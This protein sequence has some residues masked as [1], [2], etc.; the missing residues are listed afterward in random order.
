MNNLSTAQPELNSPFPAERSQIPLDSIM[1]I[2]GFLLLFVIELLAILV[3]NDGK[4]IYTMDDTYIHLAVAEEIA[5]GHYGVNNPE[6]SAPCSSALWP[7]LIAPLARTPI[8]EYVP[9]V[10]NAL[11]GI[12]TCWFLLKEVRRVMP[13]EVGMS[14]NFARAA[15][16]GVVLL[17]CNVMGLVFSGMEH[18]LQLLLAL[19][20]A[21]GIVRVAKTG[22]CDKWLIIAAV[23]GPLIRYENLALTAVA[24]IVLLVKKRSAQAVLIGAMTGVGLGLFSWFLVANG[25]SPMPSS[26]IAKSH[27]AGDAGRIA[28]TWFALQN[29]FIDSRGLIILLLVA[30]LCG[31]ALRK[32]AGPS[33]LAALALAG[34][35]FLHAC[36]GAYGWYHRY[37]CYMFGALIFGLISLA[38]DPTNGVVKQWSR[39]STALV[40]FF[41]LVISFPYLIGLCTVPFASNNIYEQQFQMHRFVTEW[42]KKP[43]AVNDLGWVSY[44]NDRYVLDLWGLGSNKALKARRENKDFSWMPKMAEEHNVELAMVYSQWVPGKSVGWIKVG[45][46]HLSRKRITP[47]ASSVVFFATDAKYISEI[48]EKLKDFSESVPPGVAVIT[49]SDINKGGENQLPR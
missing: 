7:F 14:S 4:F 3:L 21:A 10:L 38:A 25:Q 9:L 33:K 28:S 23:C 30:A 37:E 31:L 16:T 45:E 2:G 18:N 35:G 47:A 36:F 22:E 29:S 5:R 46:I 12:M 11:L 27:L 26:I 44:R 6:F 48:E 32:G 19:L 13:E 40:C 41:G 15:A 39:A 8:S 24:C 49:R 42:W 34:A 20:V 43:V 17:A 1:V